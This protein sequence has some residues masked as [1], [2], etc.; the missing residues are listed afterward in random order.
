[1]ARQVGKSGRQEDC[2]PCGRSPG[3]GGVPP[4]CVQ[5]GSFWLFP[6]LCVT[7]TAKVA[8]GRWTPVARLAHL[9]WETAAQAM[10]TRGRGSSG[11]RDSGCRLRA[12]LVMLLCRLS[13]ASGFAGRASSFLV[14]CCHGSLFVKSCAWVTGAR[15]DQ[16]TGPWTHAGQ[17]WRAF[18][19]GR[20]FP[21][22]G[23]LCAQCWGLNRSRSR[24]ARRHPW[25]RIS[26]LLVPSPPFFCTGSTRREALGRDPT[27]L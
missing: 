24:R 27:S 15:E 22:S 13:A 8:G 3:P 25:R 19:R 14:R 12:S 4:G 21:S 16:P 9:S 26:G 23:A 7:A 10:E 1:M 2:T 18:S 20:C 17:T 5:S 11:S 6:S